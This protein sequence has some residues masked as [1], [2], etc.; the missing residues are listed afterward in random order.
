MKIKKKRI[1]CFFAI[2]VFA[3][4]LY[5]PIHYYV[6]T[7]KIYYKF[8]SRIQIDSDPIFRAE[9]K[10]LSYN[11]QVFNET[12]RLFY[13]SKVW[14]YLKY[15]LEFANPIPQNIDSILVK[16]IPQAIQARDTKAFQVVISNLIISMQENSLEGGTNPYSDIR[17]YG[18]IDNDWMQDSIFLNRDIQQ[19][20]ENIFY[21]HTGKINQFIHNKPTVGSIRFTNEPEY[22]EFPDE[23]IRLLGLF[24]YWN[25]INYFYIY[26]NYSDKSWDQVLY[27]AIPH[28][29]IT[30]TDTTYRRSIYQLTNELRDTHA[31]IPPTIDTSVFG[32]YRPNFRM[33]CINDTFVISKIRVPQLPSQNFQIGDIVL[34]VDNHDIRNLYDS[35]LQYVCGGNKWS[36]QSF[37]CNAVL[38]R[39]DTTTVFTLLRKNDTITVKSRNYTAY[40]LFQQELNNE[41][42][43]RKNKLYEWIN[44]SI[45]YFNLKS[46]TPKNFNKNYKSIQP[47]A[48]IILDLRCYPNSHLISNLT[49]AFVPPNSFFAYTTYPD[50][51]FPGL[52]RY[53]KSTSQKIGNKNYFKGRVIVLINE[54]TASY[55]EYTAMALQVNP[56]TIT[57]GN[58]SSGADGNVAFFEFPG[59]VKTTFSGIGIYYPD[60]TPTQR[61]GVSIDRVAEPTIESIQ[62]NIDIAYEQAVLIAKKG[63]Y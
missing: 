16:S 62:N 9:M 26:K 42:Q 6:Q 40:D 41:K 7:L 53:C 56:K 43:S 61:I 36:N 3:V 44:D 34:K 55:A 52:V 17:E 58:S 2:F 29:R 38:S 27:E 33:M 1:V 21:S 47:A 59:K 48:V 37:G 8:Q 15:F 45:A 39:N 24:R 12:G 63:S 18:L 57:V 13:L 35:S 49:N 32:R 11:P 23:T 50:T 25:I 46:A 28:F 51:R 20:L 10:P 19:R 14:G 31:S 4:L 54:F 5:L 22:L 30:D 60:L